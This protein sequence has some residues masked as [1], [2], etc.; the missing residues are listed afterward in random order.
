MRM[1]MVNQRHLHRAGN[2]ESCF[3]PYRWSEHSDQ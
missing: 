1:K 2:E 3:G